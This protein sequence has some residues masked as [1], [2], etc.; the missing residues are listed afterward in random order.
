LATTGPAQKRRGEKDVRRDRLPAEQQSRV[1]VRKDSLLVRLG[2]EQ[3]YEA[4][5]E[6]HVKEFEITGTPMN[7]WVLV[8]PEGVQ[9]HDQLKGWNQRAVNFVGKLPAKEM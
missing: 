3:S 6:P 8:E 7:G 9:H 5:H 1:G 2:P 4:L